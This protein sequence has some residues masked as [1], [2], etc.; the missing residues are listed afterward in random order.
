MIIDN[1]KED[2]TYYNQTVFLMNPENSYNNYQRYT[3]EVLYPLTET[4]SFS[5]LPFIQNPLKIF[6]YNFLILCFAGY[7]TNIVNALT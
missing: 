5:G 7:I 2:N 3:K 1:Q 6:F 4:V